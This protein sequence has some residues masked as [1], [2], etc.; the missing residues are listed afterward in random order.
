MNK[1]PLV[2]VKKKT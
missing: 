2:F 1:L